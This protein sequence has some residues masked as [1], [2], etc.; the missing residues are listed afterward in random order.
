MQLLSVTPL[1][2]AI[3]PLLLSISLSPFISSLSLYAYVYMYLAQVVI[4]EPLLALNTPPL[5]LPL[6]L[7]H[8]HLSQLP[9][10]IL[11][12]YLIYSSLTYLP[13]SFPLHSFHFC[14]LLCPAPSLYHTGPA[15]RPSEWSGDG[16]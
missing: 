13:S 16:C 10:L 11:Y 5:P 2:S 15:A 6:P 1:V 12:L 14:Y 3:R 4:E 7:P 9:S 8:I